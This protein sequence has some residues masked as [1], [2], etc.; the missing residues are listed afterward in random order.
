MSVKVKR[1]I[2]NY[3]VGKSRC[4]KNKII[5]AVEGVNKTERLYFNNF[6]NG[7][8]KYSITIAKD[9][10]TDPLNLVKKL[11]KEIKRLDIDLENGDKAFCVFDVDVNPSKDRIIEEAR[12]L[13]K[14]NGISI[15]TST[16]SIELWF[17]LHFEY[18]TASMSNLEVLRRLKSFY[19]KY[20]KNE[21]IF[22]SI[23][24]KVRFAILN[25]KKLESYQIGCDKK[26]GLTNANPSTEMYKIVEY[27]LENS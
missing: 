2:N 27:L 5:I 24:D 6:D 23:N 4:V 22:L 11:S 25:A 1:N 12:K 19:P 3:R 8:Q 9:K 15:I 16:P 7:K 20:E 17:L 26:I 21:N 10:N 18:T 13:A 14:E